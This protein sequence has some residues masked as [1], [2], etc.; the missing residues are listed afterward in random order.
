MCDNKSSRPEQEI[1]KKGYQ[2]KEKPPPQP[3]ERPH[4]GSP[5]SGYQPTS[6]GD[7]PGNPPKKP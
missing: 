3:V 6:E 1:I 5:Q 4:D 2:P 7:N